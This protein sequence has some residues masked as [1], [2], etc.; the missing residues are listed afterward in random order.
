MRGKKFPWYKFL[1]S[2]VVLFSKITWSKLESR[3]EIKI[4]R[5]ENNAA[6]IHFQPFILRERKS[7]ARDFEFVYLYSFSLV[8]EIYFVSVAKIIPICIKLY[9]LHLVAPTNFF[10]FFLLRIFKLFCIEQLLNCWTSTD[11]WNLHVEFICNTT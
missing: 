8:T 11:K 1:T 3:R 10:F 6:T 9:N 7:L 5:T 2:Q 4:P